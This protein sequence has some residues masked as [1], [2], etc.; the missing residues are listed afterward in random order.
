MEWDH[1]NSNSLIISRFIV[2]L[3]CQRE[4]LSGENLLS[5]GHYWNV[6]KYI[7]FTSSESFTLV[8]SGCGKSKTFLGNGRDPLHTPDQY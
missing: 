1:M 6:K 4:F 2:F 5:T 8:Q 7:Y 3:I